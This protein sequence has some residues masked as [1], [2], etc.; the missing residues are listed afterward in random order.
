MGVSKDDPYM[1]KT[2]DPYNL[3]TWSY[4]IS[5]PMFF[6]LGSPF[7]CGTLPCL[8]DTHLE[9]WAISLCCF[10]FTLRHAAEASLRFR[11]LGQLRL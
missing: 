11:K 2:E 3:F 4:V 9:P 10:R 5:L 6:A 1:I 7:R 8:T